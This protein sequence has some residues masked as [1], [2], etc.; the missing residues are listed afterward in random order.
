MGMIDK[1]ASTL[2]YEK[3]ASDPSWAA[4]GGNIGYP[5]A[6]TARAS[7][8]LSSV[9][10]CTTAISSALAAIP[11]LIYQR[12]DSG[13]Q[14]IDRHPLSKLIRNG[15]NEGMAWPD[16]IEHWIAST[17]LT[18]NGLAQIERNARGELSGLRFIP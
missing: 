12:S 11:A 16:F 15:V 6:M 3:R 13:R 5:V 9:L 4:M 7:E 8:N 17:L 14:E 18:G 10:A 2:G 1:L